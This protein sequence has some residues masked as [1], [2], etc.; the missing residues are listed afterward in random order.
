M[1]FAVKVDFCTYFGLYTCSLKIFTKKV[2]Y[3]DAEDACCTNLCKNT[4]VTALCKKE[5]EMNL[6]T[7]DVGKTFVCSHT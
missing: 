7:K 6:I 1:H 5:K 4:M 2:T 3:K